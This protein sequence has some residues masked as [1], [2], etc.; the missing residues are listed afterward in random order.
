MDGA[1]LRCRVSDSINDFTLSEKLS[2]IPRNICNCGVSGSYRG[3]PNNC[4]VQV[5]CI[6]DGGIAYPTGI[7]CTTNQC[8]NSI[9][10][11]CTSD[12]SDTVCNET[13]PSD[14]CTTPAPSTTTPAPSSRKKKGDSE[15]QHIAII[16]DSYNIVRLAMQDSV[17]ISI[18]NYIIN[19]T[20]LNPSCENEGI[21]GIVT[22]INSLSMEDQGTLT[23]QSLPGKPVLHLSADQ[24]IDLGFYRD[25]SFHTCTGIIGNPTRELI[26]EILYVNTTEYKEI[27]GSILQGLKRNKTTTHCQNY[28][29]IEFWLLF[30]SEMQDSKIR[31]RPS[32]NVDNDTIAEEFLILILRE[33]CACGDA[34]SYRG[35]PGRCDVQVLCLTADM[36]MY[37]WGFACLEGQCRN[38][39]TGTC[40]TDCSD[41]VCNEDV[42]ADFCTTTTIPTTTAVAPK[43]SVEVSC[44][45]SFI[46]V[47]TGPVEVVCYFNETIYKYINITFKMR[48][49]SIPRPVA[50]IQ[51]SGNVV[52]ID[53]T[54]NREIELDVN[55]IRIRTLMATCD[56]GGTYGVTVDTGGTPGY[57]KG[58]LEILTKPSKPLIDKQLHTI[59]G[60]NVKH[61][62]TGNVGNPPGSIEFLVRKNAED[63]FTV[64]S[65]AV[66]S[67]EVTPNDNC[68]NEQV[69]YHEQIVTSDWN[70]TTI[71]C[72]A[73]NQRTIT[74]DDDINSY[75]SDETDI[76]LIAADNC[77]PLGQVYI[78]HPRGCGY[79]VQCFNSIAYGKQC[80]GSCFNFNATQPVCVFCNNAPP[81][82]NDTI[83]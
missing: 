8:R 48:N 81:P 37:P 80:A 29:Q 59:N 41:A 23:V 66:T 12:C 45:G 4:K 40:S 11:V 42:P 24:V 9:T 74:E 27:P 56:F 55:V 33:I 75:I 78:P 20:I 38:S 39:L 10:G 57:S 73:V 82:C 71:K 15:V 76:V 35:H 47:N 25:T 61:T 31:C 32:G 64:S 77:P 6:A 19:I 34:G 16:D 2:L 43:P 65:T 30:S 3:H 13:V 14:F 18:F 17:V 1:R 62:C 54:S 60:Q 51:D 83:S 52:M 58:I 79:Y 68:N 22:N 63:N 69:F 21:F 36:V 28:E 50:N 49:E 67:S 44:N 26:L 72:R 70:M 53:Q 5:Y 46:A 7:A